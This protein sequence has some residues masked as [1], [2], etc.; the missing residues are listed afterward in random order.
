MTLVT[1]D[2]ATGL[3]RGPIRYPDG[4][5][6]V[7]SGCRWCG[8][9]RG[10]H[11]SS[12]SRAVGLH[13]WEKPTDKQVLARMRARRAARGCRCH[14]PT[15]NPWRCE[16]DTCA[17]LD[18]LLRGWMTPIEPGADLPELEVLRPV[19]P[20]LAHHATTIWSGSSIPDDE[21]EALCADCRTPDCARYLRIQRRLARANSVRL[22]G[23]LW[24]GFTSRPRNVPAGR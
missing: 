3:R 7:P 4:R 20:Y 24:G 18:E 11:G 16:A 9:Q 6:P 21:G 23:G 2:P 13:R 15:G 14:I 22:G 10:H 1:T 5:P 8:T 12:W 17:M 19:P